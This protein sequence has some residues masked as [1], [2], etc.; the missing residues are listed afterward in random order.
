MVKIII[1]VINT[2][3]SMVITR[4]QKIFLGRCITLILYSI[5]DV[6]IAVGY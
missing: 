6:N 4:N 2:V 3:N 5:F 1:T